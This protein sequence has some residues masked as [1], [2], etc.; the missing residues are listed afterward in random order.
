MSR[1]VL[2]FYHTHTPDS[3][4]FEKEVRD[5]VISSHATDYVEIL[6]RLPAGCDAVFVKTDHWKTDPSYFDRL[7]SRLPDEDAPFERFDT[8]VCFDINGSTGI[9][10]NG[11]EASLITEKWHVIIAGLP[12]T[13]SARYCDIGIDELVDIGTEAAWFAP[14]HV[15][16]PFHRIPDTHLSTLFERASERD[17]DVALGYTTGYFPLYNLVVRNEIPFK[18]SVHDLATRHDIPMLPELDLHSV[19]PP[20]FSGCGVIDEKA[21]SSLI[22]GD[23]PTEAIFAADLYRPSG[24]KPGI[25]LRQFVRNYAMFAP[26][27]SG[28][29]DPEAVFTRSLPSEESLRKMDI[30]QHTVPLE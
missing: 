25:T 8:H 19:M 21:V 1:D 11:V 22:N 30:S 14:A 23:I 24:T 4:K 27:V 6:S 20:R 17:V 2:L 5:L 18:Q 29:D 12:L 9:V 15:G 10:I 26:L 28:W 7:E 16:M 3:N 13:D